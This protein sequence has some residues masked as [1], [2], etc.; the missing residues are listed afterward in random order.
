LKP[1][2]SP[3]DVGSNPILIVNYFGVC[4]TVVKSA[5]QD[6]ENVICDYSQSFFSNP[7]SNIPTFYSPRKFFGV[8]DGAYLYAENLD[9]SDLPR[10]A[11]AQRYVA[12]LVRI[13]E[14]AQ[15]GDFLYH[16]TE[17]LLGR[18]KI[19][20]MSAL[21]QKVL[22]S[23]HYD[24]VWES[25]ESN[26]RYLHKFLKKSNQIKISLSSI[27][28]PMHYPYL[29]KKTQ[30]RDY[31]TKHKVN[32]PQY[33]PEVL[34]RTEKG[35]IEFH[36]ANNLCALPIDQRYSKKEMDWIIELIETFSHLNDHPAKDSEKKVN[37]KAKKLVSS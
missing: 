17:Q 18:A 21:T 35:T 8:A 11:S 31:L 19:K 30:L 36:L 20:R 9:N 7:E 3:D 33:W 6:Y 27:H 2:L 14:G 29:G 15:A 13:D 24:E 4:E 26:F 37:E 5:I 34:N 25:R 10:G 22:S 28:G 12:R 32:I 1:K 16:N 23:I